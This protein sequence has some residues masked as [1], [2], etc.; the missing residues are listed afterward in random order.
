VVVSEGVAATVWVES[1]PDASSA[2]HPD[3]ER[4]PSS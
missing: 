4:A 2:S 1:P 3:A